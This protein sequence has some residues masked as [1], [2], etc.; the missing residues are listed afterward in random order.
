MEDL[1]K[2]NHSKRMGLSTPAERGEGEFK[3]RKKFVT[4]SKKETA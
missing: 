4:G 1:G 3:Q 2:K